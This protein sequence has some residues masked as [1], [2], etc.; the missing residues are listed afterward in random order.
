MS[1]ADDHG[2]ADGAST[3]GE[4][5]V[6]GARRGLGR[7][8]LRRLALMVPALLGITLVVFLAMHAAPGDPALAATGLD[9]NPGVDAL[10]RAERVRAEN[11]LDASL[12]RQYLHFLGPFD[13]SPAGHA[14]FGGSGERPWHGLLAL[15]FGRE[16]A[17]PEV[18]VASEIG[19]RLCVTAPLGL[20]ALLL[21]F[22]VAVPLGTWA[23]ARAGTRRERAVALATFLLDATPTFWLGLVLVLV[24]GATGLGWLPVVGL[25]SERFDSMG[26]FERAIDVVRHALLPVLT[27]ALASAA[28]VS[29][30]VRAGVLGTL[31]EDYVRAARAKGLRERDVVVRHALRNA[32]LPILTLFGAV[33]PVVV[34][35]SIVVETVFAIEG[36]GRYAYEGILAR[37]VNVVL[38]VTLTSALVTLI[39]IL[40]ADLAYAVAD[41]RIRHG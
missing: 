21:T 4:A 11:L 24:F 40:L 22:L 29:R 36:V 6:A 1:D 18:S 10:A 41:P 32:L 19:K 16:L 13:L 31:R 17:H 25:H 15:D 27:L 26:P 35:G 9:A 20:A 30:Q 34:T 8:V 28:Y 23:A 38:G 33:L 5:R 14:W 37:D 2:R 3:R 7:H 39:G 12:A